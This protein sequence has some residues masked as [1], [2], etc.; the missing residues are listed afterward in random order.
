MSEI[1]RRCNCDY[2]VCV[3]SAHRQHVHVGDE[4]FHPNNFHHKAGIKFVK[5][6]KTSKNIDLGRRYQIWGV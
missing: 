6:G 3:I 1:I 5:N 4:C 2:S